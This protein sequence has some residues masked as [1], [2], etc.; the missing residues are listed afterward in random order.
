MAEYLG[1]DDN[2]HENTR[3]LVAVNPKYP[4]IA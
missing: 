1:F 4:A 3:G 2:S